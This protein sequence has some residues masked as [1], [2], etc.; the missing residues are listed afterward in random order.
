MATE[1]VHNIHTE[2]IIR[3]VH[4]QGSEAVHHVQKIAEHGQEH[5]AEA[6]P[7]L[8]NWVV[9]LSHRFHEHPVVA[10]MHHWENLV[11]AVLVAGRRW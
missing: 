11:F 4:G 9:V 3:A 2:E 5:A 8:A 7:E 6:I 1:S 10:W